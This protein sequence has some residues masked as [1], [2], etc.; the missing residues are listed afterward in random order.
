MALLK[1]VV[2]EV[3]LDVADTSKPDDKQAIILYQLVGD[4]REFRSYAA[5]KIEEI[6]GYIEKIEINLKASNISHEKDIG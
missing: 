4:F 2:I 1:K 6:N 5:K 3:M